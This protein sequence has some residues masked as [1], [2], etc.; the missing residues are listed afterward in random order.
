MGKFITLEGG[1]GSGKSTQAKHLVAFLQSC[2]LKVLLTREPGGSPGAETIREL[3]VTG[4]PNRWDEV[5]EILLLFA[6][7]RDHLVKV[8]QPALEQGTWVVCDRYVDSTLAYQGY[9]RG[10]DLAAIHELHQL[11]AG[12]LRPDLTFLLDIEVRHGL[13]RTVGR[14]HGREDRFERMDLDFHFRVRKGFLELAQQAAD[15]YI[16]V[17]SMQDEEVLATEIA[18]HVSAR[19]EL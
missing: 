3:L 19:F 1:E 16:V 2:G 5:T 9:G 7:R 4:D 6:A 13:G 8:I 17:K 11:V 15:R 10:V 14:A 18:S 12:S